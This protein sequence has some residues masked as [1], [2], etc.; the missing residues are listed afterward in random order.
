MCSY[1]I[2]MLWY[3]RGYTQIN[4]PIV[5]FQLLDFNIE[6]LIW[7]MI[8]SSRLLLF[9]H[10]DNKTVTLLLCNIGG[11]WC[12]C[13][14]T[15]KAWVICWLRI[16]VAHRKWEA[17]AQRVSTNSAFGLIKI[18][19]RALQKRKSQMLKAKCQIYKILIRNTVLLYKSSTDILS[20]VFI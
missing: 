14:Q 11:H 6:L 5:G 16:G 20:T 2:T 1:S 19:E 4:N 17:S 8:R 13:T 15:V 12:R 18:L 7:V 3:T 10:M 9:I